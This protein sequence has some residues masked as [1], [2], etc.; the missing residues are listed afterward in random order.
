ML[1]IHH[2]NRF[3]TLTARLLAQ[4]G[5]GP[6]DVFAAEQLIVPSTAVRRA[7]TLAIAQHRGICAQVQFSYLAQWL[8]QQMG[9]CVPGVPA[10]SPY[11]PPVLA[12]RVH[13]A[14][15]EAEFI[16]PHPRLLAYLQGADEVMRFELAQR[17]AS[18]LDQ[19]L[20]YRSDWLAAWSAGARALNGPLPAHALADEAWLA[21][22]W[23][24]CTR[25]LAAQAPPPLELLARFGHALDAPAAPPGLPAQAHVF[26]L[27]TMPPLHIGLMQK[28]GQHVDVHV[29]VLNPCREYWFELIAPR[30]LSHLATRGRD[31]GHEVGNRLLAAWGRQTQSHIDLL[32]DRA[33]EAALDDGQFEPHPGNSLLA[34]LHNAVLS[35]TELAP[36]SVTLA[37]DD[38]SVELHVC[39]SL[40][41]ELEVLHD[42][43]L[44]LLEAA[45]AA[46]QPLLPGQV[47]VVT[48][49]LEAAAPLIDAVFSTQPGARRIPYTVT[50]RAR[51]RTGGPAGVL[52]SL[53]ALAGSRFV[54]GDV[55]ALLQQSPVARR[56]GLSGPQ[57]QQLHTWMQ[58]S[59]MR[60]ALDAEHRASLGLPADARH[61]LGDGMARLLL[62][63]ASPEQSTAPSAGA[64]GGAVGGAFGGNLG[65]EFAEPFAGLLP[66]GDAEGQNA[67]LLGTL[68]RVL[69]ALAAL[70]EQV[71]RPHSPAG[72]EALLLHTLD[73]FMQAE[74]DEADDLRELRGVLHELAATMQHGSGAQPV[75]PAVVRAAL[76]QLLDDPARGGVPTG[77]VTF[78][79]MSS[80][81]NLP[82]AVVC[83]IGLNDGAFPGPERPLEFDLMAL[84][85][86]RGDRQRRQDERNL[87]LDLLLAA[88]HSL[89][90]SHTGRS[91]RDNA[92]LPPSVLVSE[93][94]E[95]LVPAIASDPDSPAA[96]A[97]ARQRLVVEHPLQPFALEAFTAGTEPRL[98]SFNAELAWALRA[99]LVA[100]EPP[101]TAPPAGEAAPAGSADSPDSPADDSRC[102]ASKGQRKVDNGFGTEI[103]PD[104]DDDG[105]D[106][107]TTAAEPLAPFFRAP[108]AAPEASWREVPLPRLAEFL[109]NPCRSLL[110]RR[111]NLAMHR[112]DDALLDNEPLLPDWPGRSALAQRLL[113]ALLRGD[114]PQAVA[115]LARAGTEWPGGALGE[116]LLQTEL[117]VLTHFANRLRDATAAPCLPPLPLRFELLIDGQ[118]WA[119]HG[120][121]PDLRMTG[122]VR[123]RYDDTRPG[124]YLEAWLLHLVRAAAAGAVSP[125]RWL[126]RD[127]EFG[128]DAVA[129]APAVL[130]DLLR[131]Y[132]RGL[133]EPVHFFPKSAWAYM[134]SDCSIARAQARWRS[135]PRTPHAEENDPA[136]SLA[137]R[138]VADPLDGDFHTCALRVFGPLLECLN[139]ARVAP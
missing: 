60:W 86:R 101:R 25:E 54:A 59:G 7:L 111:L 38:R 119:V 121:L 21:A 102:V 13:A 124:D 72:W 115:R 45:E 73:D 120:A 40:T 20:T 138:G 88:R 63:Y 80:L 132:A 48:P 94:L 113:P 110:R 90:L 114:G 19:L 35:L 8:W 24:R 51:S 9:R 125:T 97:A 82:Y 61:T 6:A 126:S 15:S 26:A 41:R 129:D 76:S 95:V 56:F 130:A 12:W 136:Y 39:H 65:G 78:S 123:W 116:H 118:T 11:A 46:G 5:R 71:S 4:L 3:E 47:L 68:Q 122:L 33:G 134:V 42:H 52:L 96:L 69:D 53:L 58:A 18:L 49:D 89:Y 98:R 99:S 55:L 29:Y 44:G 109:R 34:Q 105:D 70:R 10:Q 16:A 127:G 103:D 22:L 17:I 117:G 64:F 91:V 50:G 36:G 133:R 28:L 74:G 107:A 104:H 85:P 32:V 108:L 135:S 2:A 66:A 43:L 137:L 84:Q 131:L 23:R 67:A 81:R 1:H 62:G 106:D 93:L 14:L 30:Q 79:S 83:A 75:A 128:F 57:L 139:D 77:R 87:F 112:D 37:H 92:P 100:P 31:P 27:P